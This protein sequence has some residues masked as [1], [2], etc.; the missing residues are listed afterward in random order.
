MAKTLSVDQIKEIQR[1]IEGEGVSAEAA[2]GRLGLSPGSIRVRLLRSG[3]A[4]ERK[5][6]LVPTN[7]TLITQ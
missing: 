1:L 3:Y 2:A 7:S 4:I 6:R 5:W